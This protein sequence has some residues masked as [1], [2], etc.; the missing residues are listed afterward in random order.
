M[1]EDLEENVRPVADREQGRPKAV[2]GEET[3]P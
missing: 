3:C 2:N 1:E